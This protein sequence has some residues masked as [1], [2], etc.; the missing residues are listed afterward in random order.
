[1]FNL[2]VLLIF[3]SY[4]NLLIFLTSLISFLWNLFHFLVDNIFFSSPSY[5]CRSLSFRWHPISHHMSLREERDRGR[6]NDIPVIYVDSGWTEWP[7]TT[8]HI[9]YSH[10]SQFS[11]VFGIS[12]SRPLQLAAGNSLRSGI[13]LSLVVDA[14]YFVRLRGG[15][16]KFWTFSSILFGNFIGFRKNCRARRFAH[17]SL[18]TASIV[19]NRYQ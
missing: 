14:W 5:P 2:T 4:I 9:G 12:C 17:W 8:L 11:A 15:I 13:S 16:Q 19:S 1:M 7:P 18:D 6:N 10:D 3:F